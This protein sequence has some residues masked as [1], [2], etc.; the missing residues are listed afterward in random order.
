MLSHGAPHLERRD[1]ITLF[2]GA[3]AA[4]P[5][6]ARA[7]QPAMPV[8]GFLSSVSQAKTRHMVAAFQRGLGEAG[9]VDGR[10]L[11]IEYHFAD[12]QYDRLPA[13]ASEMVR[14][15]VSLI[16]AAGP[17]A[18]LAAKV[19]TTSI[20]IVFVVGFDPVGA[21]L[22]MS[23]NR[24]GVMPQAWCWS[25]DSSDRNDWNSCVISFP[26]RRPSRCL[27]TR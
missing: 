11:A 16:V 8:I 13:W 25:R 15:P 17:P 22:V 1:F 12:G 10:N 2:G 18:A 9:Y 20:P 21:G 6:A 23:F 24:P 4:W 26:R 5:L 19:A 7:Q 27:P 3:A 14:R